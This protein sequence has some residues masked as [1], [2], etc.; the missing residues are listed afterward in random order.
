MTR[1]SDPPICPFFVEPFDDDFLGGSATFVCCDDCG[2]PR[3][4]HPVLDLAMIDNYF[5]D[6]DEEA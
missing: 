4:M 1:Q 3:H 2:L 5:N 6:E